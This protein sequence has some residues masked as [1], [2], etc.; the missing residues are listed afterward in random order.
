MGFSAG[1]E[2]VPV[3]QR[4]FPQPVKSHQSSPSVAR[5]NSLRKNSCF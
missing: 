5:L 4:V 2:A 1:C 3:V